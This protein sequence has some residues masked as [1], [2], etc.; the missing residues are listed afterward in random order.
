MVDRKHWLRNGEKRLHFNY[1]KGRLKACYVLLMCWKIDRVKIKVKMYSCLL[2]LRKCECWDWKILFADECDG[3]KIRCYREKWE[4][5]DWNELDEEDYKSR[6][7]V[8][9]PSLTLLL[10][11]PHSLQKKPRT[12]LTEGRWMR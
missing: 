6:V 9:L 12:P 8:V 3:N 2:R 4:K 7:W 5:W 10:R 1:E 11:L